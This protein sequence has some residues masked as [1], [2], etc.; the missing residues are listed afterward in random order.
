MGSE[1]QRSCIEGDIEAVVG[2]E[3]MLARLLFR[4]VS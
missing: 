2:A 4:L 3:R 1:W